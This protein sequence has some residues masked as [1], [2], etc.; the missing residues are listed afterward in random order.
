MKN[1]SRFLLLPIVFA[2]AIS[3]ANAQN[4]AP[5]KTQE[6]AARFKKQEF[7][8]EDRA[9]SLTDTL[10]SVVAL[11][12][13]QY[14]KAY[15]ANLTYVNKKIELKKSLKNSTDAKDP[16]AIKKQKEAIVADRKAQLATILS[17]EQAKKWKEWVQ[18]RKKSKSA[19]NE[20]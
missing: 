2:F 17:P 1:L 3:V 15:Q 12:Q 7:K 9:K 8:P 11:T 19:H 4:S 10:N 13:D 6:G 14:V 5:T 18:S 20:D 16:E